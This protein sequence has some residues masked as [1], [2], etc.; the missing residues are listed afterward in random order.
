MIHAPQAQVPPQ[1]IRFLAA[2]PQGPAPRPA[3]APTPIEDLD[4]ARVLLALINTPAIAGEAPWPPLNL[5]EA[6]A[7]LGPQQRV[8]MHAYRGHPLHLYLDRKRLCGASYDAHGFSM[9]SAAIVARL[10]QMDAMARA[11]SRPP[12]AIRASAAPFVPQGLQPPQ[13]FASPMAPPPGPPPAMLPPPPPPLPPQRVDVVVPPRPVLEERLRSLYG[14]SWFHRSLVPQLL[15]AAGKQMAPANFLSFYYLSLS[16]AGDEGGR[17]E[18]RAFLQPFNNLLIPALVPDE[19]ARRQVLER[20][21][22]A[23]A[24]SFSRAPS[25]CSAPAPALT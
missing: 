16:F 15:T 12:S 9:D 7:I 14:T 4:P 21:A 19:R 10:R 1:F 18:A 23:E 6:Q 25:P 13:R 24:A 20:M 2:P 8:H 17:R 22:I 3:A 5:Q 11:E